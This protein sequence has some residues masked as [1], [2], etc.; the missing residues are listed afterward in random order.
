LVELNPRVDRAEFAVNLF[1]RAALTVGYRRATAK[2][3]GGRLAIDETGEYFPLGAT[4]N[5][6]ITAVGKV[7]DSAPILTLCDSSRIR[8]QAALAK[9]LQDRAPKLVGKVEIN[10]RGG[11]SFSTGKLSVEFG[12]F[13]N[14]DRKVE[15]FA[16]ALREQPRLMLSRSRVNLVDPD[17]PMVLFRE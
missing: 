15:L 8:W 2:L 7:Q 3:A 9:K 17:N 10:S 12:D 4:Q 1:G 11:L 14:L 16:K 5:P 13:A 6:R